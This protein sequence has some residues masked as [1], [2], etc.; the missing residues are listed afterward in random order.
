MPNLKLT[1]VVLFSGVALS[2]NALATSIS[3][4]MDYSTEG[5]VGTIFDAG[6]PPV[7]NLNGEANERVAA[8]Y[9]LDLGLNVSV[10]YDEDGDG[11]DMTYRTNDTYDYSGTIFSS[12]TDKTDF[13]SDPT[14]ST[15]DASG[16]KYVLAKYDGQQSG[17]VLFVCPDRECIIPTYPANFGT[18]DTTKYAMSHWTGFNTPGPAALALLGIGLVGLGLSS[19]RG[20]R[21]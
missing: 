3:S 14:T 4:P 16:Y 10:D 6:G 12:V 20:R 9:L 11:K 13:D 15:I 8:Q 7:D 2:G 19:R 21:T 17:Y 5:V 1:A 18:T